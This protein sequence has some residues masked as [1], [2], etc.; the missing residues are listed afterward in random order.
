[1]LGKI[2]L[3][4]ILGIIL[5]ILLVPFGADISYEGGNLTVCAKFCGLLIQILPKAP[6]DPNAPPK[7]KKPKKPKRIKKKKPRPE[8]SENTAPAPK[9]KM[10]LSFT[11]DEIL[12]LLKKVLRGI[13]K[14]FRIKVDRF[15]LHYVAGGGDPY[16]TA[17]MF[18]YVNAA[19]SALAPVCAKKFRSTDADVRTDIDF[20]LDKMQIDFGI[21]VTLRLWTILGGVNTILFGALGILIKNKIRLFFEKRREKKNGSADDKI[22]DAEQPEAGRAE[23]INGNNTENIQVEERNE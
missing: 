4:I 9:K 6:P 14:I 13:G 19:L 20:S 15:K 1:M 12:S 16:D 7:E 5:F 10:K 17:V 23:I 2:I 18:G 3:W 21:A 8:E 22:I 11:F